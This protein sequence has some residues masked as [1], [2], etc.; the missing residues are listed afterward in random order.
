MKKRIEKFMGKAMSKARS[1]KE[2][3]QP[4]KLIVDFVENWEN[5][6]VFY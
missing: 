6:S 5:F 4:R 1:R 2:P 3:K